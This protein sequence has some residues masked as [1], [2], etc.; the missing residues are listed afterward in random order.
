[1]TRILVLTNMYPPHHLGGYELSCWDVMQRL[2][3]R[4]HE[5]TVLTTR[6]RVP[7][8]VD[9]SEPAEGVR[10]DLFFY[11]DDHRIVKPALRDRVRLERENQAA[12]RSALEA[13]RPEVVSA[14]NMGAMSLGL[15]TTIVESR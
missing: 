12:L 15:L 4:G 10:R 8:V 7:G 9:P 1:M 2:R 14:W 11:W 6:M 5:V 13:S 3:A